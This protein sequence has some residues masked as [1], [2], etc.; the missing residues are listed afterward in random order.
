MIK[1]V[2]SN[3]LKQ[4][5]HPQKSGSKAEEPPCLE[6]LVK[7]SYSYCQRHFN[8]GAKNGSYRP[9]TPFSLNRCRSGLFFWGSGKIDSERYGIQMREQVNIL[10]NIAHS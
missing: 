10:T 9:K 1:A 2:L 4:W 7:I 8:I 6:P 5:F 3:F